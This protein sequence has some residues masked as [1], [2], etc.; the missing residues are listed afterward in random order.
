MLRKKVGNKRTAPFVDDF[1]VLPEKLP[2]FLPKFL[3]ILKKYG[4]KANIAGHAGSGNLHVIPLM[5]LKIESERNKIQPCADEI[6][7]LVIE[8]GGTITAEHNDGLMRTPYV[9]K[10]FGLEVYGIFEEIKNIFDP[11]N[12]FNP[13]KKVGGSKEYSF[14]HMKKD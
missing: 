13:G 4:I 11:N 5:D 14:S 12:I 7:A 1:C 9:K 3:A 6:Y 8:F 2:E 10:M